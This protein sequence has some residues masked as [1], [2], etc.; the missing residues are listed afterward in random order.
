MQKL[1]LQIQTG[2]EMACTGIPPPPA[3]HVPDFLTKEKVL[4]MAAKIIKLDNEKAIKCFGAIEEQSMAFWSNKENLARLIAN[5]RIT[6]A[7]NNEK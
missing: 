6:V 3:R 7:I 2:A 1:S 5:T 4:Q